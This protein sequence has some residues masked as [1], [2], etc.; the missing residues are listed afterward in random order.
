MQP[1]LTFWLALPARLGQLVRPLGKVPH[2]TIP[3]ACGCVLLCLWPAALPA[4]DHQQFLRQYCFDCHQGE[5]SE[6][7]LD[8]SQLGNEPTTADQFDRWVQIVD[9]V[10]SGEMPP[11]DYESISSEQRQAFVGPIRQRLRAGQMQRF[12]REGRV[13]GRR[14]TNLQLERTLHDLLG[15]DIPLAR[16]MPEIPKT[17]S[18]STLADRQAISHF[19]LEQHLK[20][21]DLALDEAWRRALSQPDEWLRPMTAKDISRTRT[22]TREPEFID[23]AAVIWSGR[24]SFYGRLPATTAKQSGWYRFRFTVQ[25]VNKPAERGVWCTVRTG[26]CV[27]SAPLMSW[28][29]AFEATEEPREVMFEA[30]LPKDHML[31]VRPGDLTLKLARFAGG[32]AANGEGGAQNVP[33]LQIHE[34][35]MERI[36]R[37]PSNDQLR[38]SLLGVPTMAELE[39]TMDAGH[40]L[41]SQ[42]ARRAFRRPV[43]EEHLQPYIEVFRQALPGA[44]RKLTPAAFLDALR[45]SYRAILCSPRFLYFVEQPGALDDYAIASRLSYAL[46]HRPPDQQLLQQAERSRLRNSEV[47]RQEVARMLE[48]ESGKDFVAHFSD[49]WLELSEIDFTDPDRRLY[50][51]FDMIVQHSMLQE[52]RHFLQHLLDQDASI[53]QLIDSDTTF[54]NSRLARYYEL[55]G[56]AFEDLT[57][58][59]VQVQVG[60]DPRRGG[61]LGQGAILKVTANGTNTSPVLRGVWVASRI[62]G[63]QIPPPP[64]SVPAIEPDI[65]GAKTIREQLEKHRGQA[66]CASCH[67]KFDGAGFALE[68]FDAAGQW[69]EYYPRIEGR[70]VARGPAVDASYTTAN[71][72]SFSEFQEFKRLHAQR[73]DQL[74]RSFV[75]HVLVFATGANISF[76]DREEIERIVAEAEQSDFGFRSL[77]QAALTSRIFLSK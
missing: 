21:V 56:P 60:A 48:T 36:H 71:G 7:G 18:F 38:Q 15:I 46:W 2:A 14:L 17:D 31:Q 33:G 64:D 68:N 47:I 76:S 41:I 37:G 12:E 59:T 9:R 49:E 4:E 23:G 73:P 8:L 54:L 51:D 6:A 19:H 16:E 24:L 26:A 28:V 13:R 62:L 72:S 40:Q 29:G 65:R 42:F 75:E 70:K 43:A 32:Q 52:T 25:A 22:R 50:P 10:T 67:S 3:Y 77:L 34:M 1:H 11:P 57:D 74:A 61:L 69:R 66:E 44:S 39:P 63:R 35:R 53:V 5:D 58:E 45:T 55:T 30:W 20:V 27:S